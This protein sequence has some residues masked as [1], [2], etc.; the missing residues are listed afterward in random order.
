MRKVGLITIGQSPRVDVVPEIRM[1]LEGADVEI[2]ECGALDKLSREEIEA[3]T[4]REGEYVLVTRLRD[5]AEVKVARERI[6]PLMQKC[7]NS[8]EPSVD[9]LGLL[10]TGEFPELKSRKLL[11]EPSDLLL[12]VVESLKV[13]KLGVVVPDPAQLG[14]TRRKW[15]KISSDIKILSV[16]P[17]TGTLNSLAEASKELSDRDLIVLDCIGFSIEAKRVVATASGK[18]V[19]IPRTLLGRVLRE[20]IEV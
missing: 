4:P 5:G 13:G 3:L 18:P 19:L 2:V 14:L 11:I 10:C 8:L 15:S 1:V 9:V 20:L 6:L 7:I 12:K 17:Y 16:S